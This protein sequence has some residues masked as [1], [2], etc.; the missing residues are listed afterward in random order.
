MTIVKEAVLDIGLGHGALTGLA[1]EEVDHEANSLVGV[2]VRAR[3][4]V[5]RRRHNY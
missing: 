2:D 5:V 4:W 1:D 3:E